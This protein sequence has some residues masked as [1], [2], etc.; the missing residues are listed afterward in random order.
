MTTIA[1]D[2]KTLAADRQCTAGGTPFSSRKVFRLVRPSDGEVL[3]YGVCG[4]AAEN[5]EFMRCARDGRELPKFSDMVVICVDSKRR[6]WQA[7][8]ASGM[9]WMRMPP[10]WAQGSGA[11]YALGAMYAGSS[12]IQAIKIASRLDVH[13]G[14]GVDTV[15]L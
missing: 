2:G 11:N 5:A 4:D 7:A 14:L 8:S 12:A 1:F 9:W 13:T 15:R 10:I 3:L 6:V